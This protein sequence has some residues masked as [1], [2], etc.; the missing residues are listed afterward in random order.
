LPA[1]ETGR[2]HF[3]AKITSCHAATF[4]DTVIFVHDIEMSLKKLGRRENK[5]IAMV[6]IE[7]FSQ[8]EAARLL[9]CG[10]QAVRRY[11]LRGTG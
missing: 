8:E 5:L 1:V 6:V 10:E 7:E 3:C 4:E 2:L 9:Q 11:Y